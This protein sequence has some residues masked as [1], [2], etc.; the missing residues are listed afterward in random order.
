MFLAPSVTA[1]NGDSEGGAPTTILDAQA[2]GTIVVASR[3]ADIPFIVDDGLTGFLAEEGQPDA[4]AARIGDAIDDQ[5]RWPK[6]AR[7]ARAAVERQHSDASVSTV[8]LAVYQEVTGAPPA[9]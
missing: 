5:A 8:M 6:I 3:H 9:R 1:A 7:A 2:T 4:L